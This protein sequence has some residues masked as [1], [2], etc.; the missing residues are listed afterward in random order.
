MIHKTGAQA[1]DARDEMIKEME[2]KICPLQIK[3]AKGGCCLGE[4]CA[5]FDNGEITK[6]SDKQYQITINP[7]CGL[8]RK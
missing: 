3:G 7:H 5:I 8:T 6:H 1:E 2:D 4:Q